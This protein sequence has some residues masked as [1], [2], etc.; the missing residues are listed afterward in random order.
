[1]ASE[2]L[3]IQEAEKAIQ[4]AMKGAEPE[5]KEL[6]VMP[7]DAQVSLSSVLSNRQI[8]RL[9]QPTPAQHIG[10]LSKG[11]TTFKFV[12]GGYMRRELDV[13][14]GFNW[15]FEIISS[16]RQGDYIIVQ[17]KLTGR[18]KDTQITKMQ[19]GG[20]AVKFK[21]GTQIP[22]DI[23]NDYKAA[24][25]D[26]LKKC[27]AEFG[28]CRDIYYPNEFVEAKLVQ[29]QNLIE[30][31]AEK[32]QDGIVQD[33]KPLTERQKD[34]ILKKLNSMKPTDKLRVI[35]NVTGR[36]VYEADKLSDHDWKRIKEELNSKSKV[37]K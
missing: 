23:G 2:D 31:E 4:K 20:A 9:M 33:A 1:M 15:D 12:S 16:E 3:D 37:A 6:L 24:A 17:G 34:N 8:A 21:K 28:I 13:L 27:A 22:L 36:I 30:A 5:V 18:I 7:K 29:K 32:V 14:F 11:G 25:T 19:F 26:A 10:E 35:K